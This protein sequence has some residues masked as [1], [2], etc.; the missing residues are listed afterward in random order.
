MARLARL[1]QV[2]NAAIKREA[3]QKYNISSIKYKLEVLSKSEFL[4]IL[5]WMK[6]RYPS[7]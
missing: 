2:A 1:G 6:S 5:E 4:E 7:E 3:K